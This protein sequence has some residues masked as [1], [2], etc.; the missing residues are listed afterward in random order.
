MA[1]E[2]YLTDWERYDDNTTVESWPATFAAVLYEAGV[3]GAIPQDF[4]ERVVGSVTI[5][6][7]VV[8]SGATFGIYMD[9]IDEYVFTRVLTEQVTTIDFNFSVD[10]RFTSMYVDFDEGL[11]SANSFTFD[12][13]VVA[14]YPTGTYVPPPQPLIPIVAD[15]WADSD[16]QPV[17]FPVTYEDTDYLDYSASVELPN[18]AQRIIISFK[19][20]F[21]ANPRGDLQVLV[22]SRPILDKQLR[23]GLDYDITLD[24]HFD[25]EP[26]TELQLTLNYYGN[27]TDFTVE[28]FVVTFYPAGTAPDA[29]GGGGE[30]VCFWQDLAG[31]AQICP[32]GGGGGPVDGAIVSIVY[33]ST[34][35]DKGY[36]VTYGIWNGPELLTPATGT[37]S[38]TTFHDL[39]TYP[40]VVLT[41]PSSTKVVGNSWQSD[42]S[43]FT[44]ASTYYPYG[45]ELDIENVIE[46]RNDDPY[47]VGGIDDPWV[48][49]YTTINVASPTSYTIVADR[50]Y[51]RKAEYPGNALIINTQQYGYQDANYV[52]PYTSDVRAGIHYG[53]YGTPTEY[54]G[55][56]IGL[57]VAVSGF[58]DRTWDFNYTPRLEVFPT[59]F[60]NGV[61]K[62]VMAYTGDGVVLPS[63]LFELPDPVGHEGS[64]RGGIIA[65]TDRQNYDGTIIPQVFVDTLQDMD[66]YDDG[67]VRLY[68]G[69]LYEVDENGVEVLLGKAKVRMGSSGN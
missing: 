45:I 5:T 24:T 33:N 52:S 12:N 7:D 55:H 32:G 54:P 15:N 63:G 25:R 57:G 8:N 68:V 47:N 26:N 51:N 3:L 61:I 53:N 22:G 29:G 31:V 37:Y 38:D 17:S 2:I 35:R 56:A 40:G 20:S 11:G 58:G 69:D 62:N 41:V 4:Y 16:S 46:Q 1:G 64:P 34:D 23:H 21:S 28:E 10:G 13:L 18:G 65:L 44:P 60:V 9:Y 30:P 6:T 14:I 27:P 42:G 48:Y 67:M 19:A 59:K 66:E 39:L 43:M 50:V 36:P 49:L